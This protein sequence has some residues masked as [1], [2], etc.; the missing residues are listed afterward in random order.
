M[1]KQHLIKLNGILILIFGLIAL[2]FPNITLK[3]LGIYFAI[4][5]LIGGA[6]LVAEAFRVKRHGNK[7]YMPLLEGIIGVLIGLIILARPEVVATVFVIIMGICAVITGLIFLFAYSQKT[8]PAFSN[9][10]MLVISIISLLTG[11]FII[12]NPFESTRI[13]TVLIG[14]YAIIYGIFSLS[15]S[16]KRYRQ[17]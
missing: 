16:A 11:V 6:V 2:F 14:I 5:L 1:I 13:V 15:N 9:S 4:S 12:I 8:L 17:V 10:V 7:W 3:A